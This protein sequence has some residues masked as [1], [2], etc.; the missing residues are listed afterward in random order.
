MVLILIPGVLVGMWA[1]HFPGSQP[2]ARVPTSASTAVMSFDCTV[3]PWHRWARCSVSCGVGTTQRLRSMTKPSACPRWAWPKLRE[4]KYCDAGPCKLTCHLGP[5]GSWS[6]CSQRCDNGGIVGS[7]GGGGG[8]TAADDDA[9]RA[10]SAAATVAAVGAGPGAGAGG[11]STRTRVVVRIDGASARERARLRT[12]ARLGMSG[13]GGGGKGGS[14]SSS[15]SQRL[16]DARLA[17]LAAQVCPPLWSKRRCNTQPCAVDCVLGAWGRWHTV[18]PRA[19]AGPAAG[20]GAGASADEGRLCGRHRRVLVRQRAGGVACGALS[21]WRA[22]RKGRG[23]GGGG[24]G[25]GS[26]GADIIA[27]DA[28]TLASVIGGET[29]ALVLFSGR[30]APPAASAAAQAV[31]P[32]VEALRRRVSAATAAIVGAAFRAAA[33]QL[34]ARSSSLLFGSFDCAAFDGAVQ[35]ASAAGAAGGEGAPR[36]P[37]RGGNGGALIGDVDVVPLRALRRQCSLARACSGGDGGGGSGS[38]GGGGGGGTSAGCAPN[39]VYLYS[40]G[41]A[42]SLF[43]YHEAEL[44]GAADAAATAAA[45]AATAAADKRSHAKQLRRQQRQQAGQRHSAWMPRWAASAATK[46]AKHAGAAAALL[47]PPPPPVIVRGLVKWLRT[48]LELP[49]PV[50][51]AGRPH[52]ANEFQFAKPLASN[53]DGGGGGGG[54]GSGGVTEPSSSASATMSAGRRAALLTSAFDATLRVHAATTVPLTHAPTAL[55]SPQAQLGGGVRPHAGGEARSARQSASTAA[56]GQVTK[57]LVA[58][59]GIMSGIFIGVLA[60]YAVQRMVTKEPKPP[61]LPRLP[62]RRAPSQRAGGSVVCPLQ[63]VV[64][65]GV[66]AAAEGAIVEG[67]TFTMQPDQHGVS[68]AEWDAC[69]TGDGI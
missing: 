44:S 67:G 31:P 34:E 7:G 18:V 45:A 17:K 40:A 4:A 26:G 48:S 23:G 6:P 15:S 2:A 39:A 25:G 3:S 55:R 21:Q 62:R 54:S 12:Q 27:L 33:A 29:A 64:G 38:G 57:A 1:V 59:T 35:H 43:R 11:V 65:G 47:L 16:R 36:A 69:I 61:R 68:Q 19:G 66:G 32:A 24:G 20:A 22:C 10:D 30:A 56:L 37:D 13:G 63:P 52:H 60:I 41:V 5:W 50:S 53:S 51:A 14:S 9:S 49:S 8:G 28:D 58:A 42:P 46:R